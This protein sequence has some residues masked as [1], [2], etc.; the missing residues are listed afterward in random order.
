MTPACDRLGEGQNFCRVQRE[1]KGG[2]RIR[3]G[4]EGFA[5]LCLTTWL[6]RQAQSTTLAET[7]EQRYALALS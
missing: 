2:T 3:T 4:G 6:C 1:L 5:D 7:F